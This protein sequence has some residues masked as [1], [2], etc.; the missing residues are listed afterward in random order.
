MSGRTYT[1]TQEEFIMKKI[2][3]R[4]FVRPRGA[5]AYPGIHYVWF[6]TNRRSV[7]QIRTINY[8]ED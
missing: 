4:V 6:G 3:L 8:E 5:Y 7:D 2:E 1:R